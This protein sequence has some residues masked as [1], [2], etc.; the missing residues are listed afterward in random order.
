MNDEVKTLGAWQQLMF[1]ATGC[2]PPLS[3]LLGM[4]GTVAILIPLVAAYF[5]RNR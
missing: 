1:R 4:P 5:T 2:S 3:L